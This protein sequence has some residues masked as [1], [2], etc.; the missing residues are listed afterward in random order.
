MTLDGYA[1]LRFTKDEIAED[2]TRVLG[3]IEALLSKKRTNE[4]NPR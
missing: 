2:P 1:V 4:G 3:V